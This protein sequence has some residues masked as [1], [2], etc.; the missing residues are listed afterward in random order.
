MTELPPR[1]QQIVQAHADFIVMVVKACSNAEQRDALE[2]VLR[3]ATQYGQHSLVEAVRKILAGNRGE[4]LM[5][6][7]DE[8]D[9]VIVDAILRGLQNPQTLP[10]PKAQAN[11]AAAA[12]GLA[13][14]IHAAAKGNAEAL[15][16]AAGMAEQ[17]TAAGGG[18]ARLGAIMRKLINGERDPDTLCAGMDSRTESLVLSILEELAKLEVH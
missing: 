1:T 18:L 3:S 7:L 16:V 17:M 5:L 4:E 13:H 15:Q 2:P 8:D 11:P 12:P 14:M 10:D 6:G 9:R